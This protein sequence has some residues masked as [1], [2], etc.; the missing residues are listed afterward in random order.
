MIQIFCPQTVW[1][2]MLNVI[3]IDYK[4]IIGYEY[5]NNF[6]TQKERKLYLRSFIEKS[7]FIESNY[8]HLEAPQLVQ[9]KQPSW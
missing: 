4:F 9:I 8:P 6:I 5:T 3:F 2:V 7:M 1:N